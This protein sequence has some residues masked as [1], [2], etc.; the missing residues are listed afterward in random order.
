MQW[1]IRQIASQHLA[2]A[3]SVVSAHS[4]D[5]PYRKPGILPEG[6]DRSLSPSRTASPRLPRHPTIVFC[7][8]DLTLAHRLAPRASVATA[9][10][11]Y[12]RLTRLAGVQPDGHMPAPK[13]AIASPKNCTLRAITFERYLIYL[14]E[15][16]QLYWNECRT[17]ASIVF[18]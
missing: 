3:D 18:V 7:P 10:S 15:C 2:I 12:V 17:F 1:Y 8:A 11:R 14:A 16:R 9:V 13:N 5:D 6:F 4:R